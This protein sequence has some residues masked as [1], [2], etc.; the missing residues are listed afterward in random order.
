MSTFPVENNYH[1]SQMGRLGNDMTDRTQQN[2]QNGKHLNAMLYSPFREASVRG[3]V[4]FA[5]STSG[6]LV[7]RYQGGAGLDGT[8]VDDESQLWLKV[9]QQRPVEK[10]QLMPRAFLTVPYL[11]RGSCD[12]VMESQLLQGETVRGKKSVTTVMEQS[13]IDPKSYPLEQ[14]IVD[15]V[16]DGSNTIEELAMEGWVRGGSST[17]ESGEKYFSKK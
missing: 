3:H 16:Q 1:F 6:L 15:R 10:L 11:G 8:V 2:V 13:F 9:G 17:R 5:S 7:N 4:D 14:G 12:P